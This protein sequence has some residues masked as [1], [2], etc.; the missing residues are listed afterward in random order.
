MR[1]INLFFGALICVARLPAQGASFVYT[2]N[3]QVAN[4]VSA[5]SIGSNGALTAVPGSPFATGGAGLGVG[6][7]PI[8]F[9][10]ITGAIVK[11]VLYVA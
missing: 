5:F 3:D 8:A 2:N 7:G 11:D 10:H 6:L 9:N 1:R 4:S